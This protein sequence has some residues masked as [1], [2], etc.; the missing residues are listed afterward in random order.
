MTV[1][2]WQ[3]QFMEE[4]FYQKI[5][6]D[7]N[8]D[9]IAEDCLYASIEGIREDFEPIINPEYLQMVFEQEK[10][11]IFGKGKVDVPFLFLIEKEQEQVYRRREGKWDVYPIGGYDKIGDT[12]QMMLPMSKEILRTDE[13]QGIIMQNLCSAFNLINAKKQ[14]R[15]FLPYIWMEEGLQ[16]IEK[17][18]IWYPYFS[19]RYRVNGK[20]FDFFSYSGARSNRKK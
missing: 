3:N 1:V 9:T 8:L 2:F 18:G 11:W 6:V 5:L 4:L 14:Y 19:K 16:K 20:E 10:D 7:R 12:Y 17:T 13:I 15:L